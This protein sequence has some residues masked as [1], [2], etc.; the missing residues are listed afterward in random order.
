MSEAASMSR[1]TIVPT[2]SW[3]GPYDPALCH[4]AVA[5]LE[6][7]RVLLF[8]AMPF[9]LDDDEQALVRQAAAEAVDGKGGKNVSYDPATAE[10]KSGPLSE[11]L[12]AQL[13]PTL[14]RFSEMAARL[15]LGLSPGYAAGLTPG[16]TSFRPSS[17][18]GR[19]TSWRK[20]DTRL[21]VD[22][23]PSK[24]V[25]GRRILR[26]FSN[27]DPMGEARRWRLGEPF[28]THA[29]RFLPRLPKPSPARA[30]MLS[31]LGVTRGVQSGYDQLMLALHDAAKQD[32]AY[33]AG[34]DAEL[35]D[36]PA[37][38]SWIVYTDQTPHAALAGRCAF[39]Q[40]FYLD[41]EV[42]ADPAT[43]PL[44]VLQRLTD[45]ALV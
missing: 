5:A 37:G 43:T 27:V 6:S 39:E 34:P 3:S 10:C 17:V 1:V 16:R 25:R 8:P 4:E 12:A 11:P 26:V 13:A 19:E 14:A 30:W 28:E 7:G 32:A 36:F 9:A 41:P 31:K 20:D 35:Q 45:R 24:P 21:H 23:F 42:M 29:Q 40:T 2:A 44:A 15:V 38:S 18:E 22:S 33:Q